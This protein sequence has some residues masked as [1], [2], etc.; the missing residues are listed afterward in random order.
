MCVPLSRAYAVNCGRIICH[1]ALCLRGV[2][3]PSES[4]VHVQEAWPM[5]QSSC[6]TD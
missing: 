6:T 4:P 5:R 2:T 1:K 3:C